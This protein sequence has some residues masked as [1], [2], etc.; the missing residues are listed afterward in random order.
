M[1]FSTGTRNSF[2]VLPLA[3][4]L[5]SEWNVAVA[6]ILNQAFAEMLGM[7]VFIRS[8]PGWLLREMPD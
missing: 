7:L 8:V 5:P 6:V 1:I 3:L 2:V 4:A